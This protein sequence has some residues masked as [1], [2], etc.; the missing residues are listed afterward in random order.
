M[1][2]GVQHRGDARSRGLGRGDEEAGKGAAALRQEAHRRVMMLLVAQ[3][4]EDGD[5]AGLV[6]G[7][8]G[9]E[10]RLGPAL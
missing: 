6:R 1:V 7:E 4:Q 5:V 10:G 3:Q 8:Q 9:H 2:A